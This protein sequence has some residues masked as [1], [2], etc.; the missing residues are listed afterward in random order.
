M[1]Q[2]IKPKLILVAILAAYSAPQMAYA[3]SNIKLNKVEVVSTTPLPSVGVPINQIPSN[4]QT[5]N[6][7]DL[8]R[9]Q[10]LDIT[11]YM[12]RNLNGINVNNIQNN[13]LQADIS[14][15]GFIASPL[16]GTPQGLS[17]Y[18]DGVRMNQPFGDVV[19]WDLIPKNAI[20]GMQ[21]MPGSNPMFGL[22]TLGGAISIQ[23]KDGRNSPGGA[24]QF[25]Y[26]TNARKIGE[27]EYGGFKDNLDWFV[28]ATYFDENGWRDKSPTEFGQLFGKLGWQGE[29]TNL[30]LT[31]SYADTDLTGNGLAPKSQNR[32]DYDG[33][34]TSPDNTKNV[35]NFINLQL[36]HYF[37]DAINLSGN[38]YYKKLKTKTYNGDIN[39]ESMPEVPGGLGQ[40]MGTNYGGANAANNCLAQVLAKDEP[41]EK[42]PGIINRTN[43]EQDT[44]GLFGQ[45]NVVN[46]L[47][48]MNNIFTVGAG[49][50]H[51]RIKFNQTAEFADIVGRATV[52]TGYMA[53]GTNGDIDGDPDDRRTR[54]SGKNTVYSIYGTDT[55]AL[56]DKLSVTGSARY[57]HVRVA[58]QD[59]L[60]PDAADSASLTGT[61]NFNRINPAIGLTYAQSSA[62]NFY[63]GY[64]EGSRAPT[65]V[66]LGCANE[67]AP[68]RL[69]NS[70]AGDPPLNQVVTKSWDAGV[71]G[72]L[73]QT[74][75]WNAGVFTATNHDDIQ[76]VNAG[77]TGQGF[78]KNFGETRRRGFEAAFS[79][80]YEA[81]NYGASYTYLD[82]SY[83]SAETINGN[84]TNA[85]QPVSAI[86]GTGANLTPVGRAVRI[87]KGDKIPLMPKNQLKLFG[88][89]KFTPDFELGADAQLFSD[90]YVR[91][92]EGNNHRAGTVT[93]DCV[94]AINATSGA[95]NALPCGNRT[96]QGVFKGSGTVAGYT[97]VNMF[98]SY[99][100]QPEWKLFARVNNLFDREY[101][102][103]GQLGADPFNAAG[104]ISLG[105]GTQANRTTSIGDTFVAPGAPRSA[106]IGVRYEFGGKKSAYAPSAD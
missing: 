61:H 18:M 27:F 38:A 23:T 40:S 24:V 15:R 12:F 81:F 30:K 42:C 98:A 57:N 71:R 78:F 54:I 92:N 7:E 6:A 86:D 104:N 65:S 68:C 4:V 106:W 43:T 56:N 85:G 51:S 76:F 3:E 9:T 29:N 49:A 22:N 33:V 64:N 90:A 14:Y 70:F 63:G 35:S 21:L 91:G 72:K 20:M 89:Y 32:R 13:P 39:D 53:D 28:A 66:E 44:F 103:A 37:T 8:E 96:K 75:N 2:T 102:S 87:S 82:A 59:K 69:P 94:G 74:I 99:K 77:S 105:T 10:S 34:F 45:V 48:D 60:I 101:A 80:E 88:S 1:E 46:K 79:G 19:S 11:D 16:L 62:L 58:N 84:F 17:L 5:I 52:G 95:T 36:D 73:G 100:I 26:G 25:T 55:L 31:Y 47:F 50:E 41:G 97:V 83:Q 93:Y 67:N